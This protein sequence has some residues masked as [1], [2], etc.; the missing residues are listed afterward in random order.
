MYTGGPPVDTGDDPPFGSLRVTR[1]RRRTFDGMSP[2]AFDPE[3]RLFLADMV[4]PYG[5]P[6]R[7]D[8]LDAGAGQ[9]YGE[10]AEALIQD[11]VTADEP[12]DLLVLAFGIHDIRL[13][14]A[15][16]A[17]LSDVCPGDPMAFAVCDQGAAAAFTALRLIG[18]YARSGMCRRALLLVAEQSALHYEPAEPAVIP[19]RHSAVALLCE[20]SPVGGSLVVR[21]HADVSPALA[22]A[23]LAD[24]V[25]ALSSGRSDVTLVLGGGLAHF[26]DGTLADRVVLASPGQ[27]FTGPWW[28]LAGGLADWRADG[29]LVLL[30]EYDAALRYLSLSTVDVTARVPA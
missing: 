30:A 24:N 3:L 29:R 23:L 25:A 22:G 10:M 16:A 13:G 14:R 2:A 12:V 20:R 27:P 15:T 6:L 17:Y 26:V 5:L 28:T 21:Q 11:T 8:L 4:R 7:D 9:S 1:A 19:D 18:E